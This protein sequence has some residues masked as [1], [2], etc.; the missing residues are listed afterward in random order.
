MSIQSLLTDALS[1][2]LAPL[3][4]RAAK[5]GTRLLIKA[6]LLLAAA[7]F[8]LAAL[9]ALIVAFYLWIASLAGPIVAALA[10]AA[11]HLLAGTLALVLALREEPEAAGPE[12]AAPAPKAG[13]ETRQAADPLLDLWQRSGGNPEQMAVLTAALIAKR[14]GPVRLAAVSLTAGFVIGRFWKSLR[15]LVENSGPILASG[16][17]ILPLLAALLEQLAANSPDPPKS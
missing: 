1:D 9:I 11:V 8:F 7:L 13:E 10:V 16:V 17:A 5:A 12:Q 3:M 14:A 6:A 4:D 2:A 15:K